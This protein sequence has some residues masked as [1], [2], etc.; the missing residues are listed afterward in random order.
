MYRWK[1]LRTVVTFQVRFPIILTQLGVHSLSCRSLKC[2]VELR[3]AST[4]VRLCHRHSCNPTLSSIERSRVA[5]HHRPTRRDA[6]RCDAMRRHHWIRIHRELRR[7]T[8]SKSFSNPPSFRVVPPSF[9]RSI[10]RWRSSLQSASSPHLSTCYYYFS[11]R[12]GQHGN[13]SR[14]STKRS[15]SQ[16]CLS[17]RDAVHSSKG[18]YAQ[19]RS[20][21]C[22]DLRRVTTCEAVMWSNEVLNRHW[23]MR[24]LWWLRGRECGRWVGVLLQMQLATCRVMS[25]CQTSAIP[26]GLRLFLP[27]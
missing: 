13:F 14:R 23:W 6:M 26:L 25:V 3:E 4:Q 7:L 1:L 5:L 11:G 22:Y 17:E 10:D 19:I 24:M 2:R 16:L 21:K 15:V 8:R 9:T 20:C 27:N 12:C 18:R